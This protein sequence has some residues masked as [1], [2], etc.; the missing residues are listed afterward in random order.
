[1]Y[2]NTGGLYE[3]GS[4]L[5]KLSLIIA[6]NDVEYLANFEKFLL[7]NYP[8]HFKLFS[9]SSSEKLYEFLAQ[10]QSI[11]LLLVSSRIYE[12]DDRFSNIGLILLLTE[13]GPA[14]AR[15]S[16]KL[17][18]DNVISIG[19]YQQMD[20]LV[21][22]IIRSYSE[23]GKRSCSISA[24]GNTRIIAV[25]SPSG[26]A[27]TSSIAAGCSILCAGRGV[28]SFYLNLEGIPSTEQFFNSDSTQSFSNVIYHLKG[29]GANL[30]L[31][32]EGAKCIDTK[33][34]VCY[35]KP[36]E[37]I[38][39]LNELTDQD[40][41]CLL[42]ELRKSA[43][44][45]YIFVDMSSGLNCLNTMVLRHS[46]IILLVLAPDMRNMLKY[47]EFKAGLDIVEHIYETNLS[48]RI[49]PVINRS[50]DKAGSVNNLIRYAGY[51]APVQIEDCSRLNE[52]E[53]STLI[54]NKA[55]L[56]GLHDILENPEF[57]SAPGEIARSG[58]EHIA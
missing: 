11:D 46:D 5:G 6:D 42:T 4:I 35:F 43:V 57:Y 8:Q 25:C 49:L 33:T 32:L 36:P 53:Q 31:K 52:F 27:G 20:R 10:P 29:R 54:E 58:G 22:E 47:K 39:E 14:G 37:N 28:R 38:R 13:D 3:E 48:G 1:L 41:D 51:R 30:Q 24:H 18:A 26:G 34:G 44:Y 50:D 23:K 45:Q 21:A 19:K 17:S 15:K 56:T 2:K 7:A 16:G 9:F 55:F 12:D 40:V